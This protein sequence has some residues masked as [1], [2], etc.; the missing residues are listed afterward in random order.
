MR[1]IESRSS[2]RALAW[3]ALALAVALACPPARALTAQHRLGHEAVP[4]FESVRLVLDPARK[5]YSGAVR[6]DLKVAA[7][8]DSFQLHAEELKLGKLALR[9][10]RAAIPATWSSG[11]HGVLT[12]R[13]AAPLAPGAYVLEIAFTHDFNTHAN[14]LYR[15]ETGGAAYAF[16]QFESQAARRA[17]PCFDEPEFKI[18]WQLTLTV[19]R[20]DL[21]VSNTPVAKEEAVGRERRVA[22]ER[23]P[24]LPSYLV[25][26]AVGPFDTVPIRGLG[27]PGRVVTVKGKAR[28][29]AEAARVTPPILAA[30]EAYFGGKY[31][32]K[33]LD[34]IAV[35]EFWAGAMENVGAVTFR[36]ERLLLD[37]AA[38][39]A[40]ER[41]ALVTTTAHEL[42]HMWFG[43]LV[44]LEWWDDIWLNES[45]ASWM[46]DK[47]SG[48][49]APE[50]DLSVGELAGF[51][52]AMTVDARPSTHAI[53]QPVDAFG[54]TDTFDNLEYDKGQAVLEMVEHWLGADVFRGGVRAY[55]KAHAW[56]NAVGADFWNALGQASGQD[57]AAVVTSFLDQEGMPLVTA[58]P[59]GGDRGELRQRRFLGYGERAAAA[60]WKI[61]VTLGWRDGAELRTSTVVLADSVQTVTL[62]GPG[63]PPWVAPDA[64]ALG[65]YRWSVAPEML[66]RL[67]DSAAAIMSPRER[68]A[69]VG[70]LVALL[71][72]GLVHGDVTLK[73]LQG[74]AWDPDAGVVS[75]V[76]DA[77]DRVRPAFLTTD[78]AKA[79]AYYV[80]ACLGPVMERIGPSPRDGEPE[81][82]TLLRP[83]LF[84]WLG[85]YGRDPNVLER[86][87]TLAGAWLDDPASV[88]PGLAEPALKLAAATG[89]STL[90]ERCRRRFETAQVP[91]DRQRALAALASF[92]DPA[93]RARAL[94][95]GLSGRLRPQETSGLTRVMEE[96]PEGQDAVFDW[97]IA[98]YDSI[99]RDLPRAFR[100]FMVLTASG[101]STERLEKARAFF[102]QPEH[103]GPATPRALVR[104]AD[105]VNECVGLREREGAAATAYLTE[106]AGGR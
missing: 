64:G 68:A 83:R 92:G 2:A 38:A 89:D 41:R 6:I 37:P 15:L 71:Q 87:H 44:T 61:P 14:S 96:T 66:A 45:F 9:S 29:A 33:K 18:P 58:T 25:A 13:T 4:T 74:F 104:L 85:A 40:G 76:I 75:A 63:T 65:Y 101:C 11:E 16:T 28:F 70:N 5:D 27:V 46:G 48:E 72:A 1:P 99:V 95:Y 100:D 23:T 34:L 10:A 81:T 53:R 86:A 21:A 84:E 8:T 88:D 26:V 106:L 24:P 98:H 56:G 20:G 82:A 93:L 69:Y 103:A 51:Q 31:P 80:R 57:V 73:L 62:P 91:A 35:P 67:A 7:A 39:T 42:A 79:F 105:Q 36:E 78:D 30:L 102:G 49:V 54:R 77:L 90:F 52:R 97:T 55:L 17:F 3:I 60:T 50:F 94:A 47:V 19:P 32:Y 43:D 59:L 22:F 12:V